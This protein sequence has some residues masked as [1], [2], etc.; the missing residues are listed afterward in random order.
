MVWPDA[1]DSVAMNCVSWYVAFAFCV[2]DGGRLPTEAEW[3]FAAAGGDE[4]R[5]YPWSNPPSTVSLNQTHAI[6]VDGGSWAAPQPVGSK[7]DG[8]GRWGHA[9]LSG[10]VYE[11]VR[12]VHRNPYGIVTCNDCSDYGK[13]DANVQYRGGSFMSGASFLKA[14]TRNG[15]STPPE[16]AR[17]DRGVRCARQ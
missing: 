15:A 7:P 1:A 6:W 11:W 3:N 2:W 14:S 9:D 12:D 16:R 8:N 10:N 5:V 13:P 17:Q 4:Q